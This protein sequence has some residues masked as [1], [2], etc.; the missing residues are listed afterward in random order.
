MYCANINDPSNRY[1]QTTFRG[2]TLRGPVSRRKHCN[3]CSKQSTALDRKIND[4][5][6]GRNLI[7]KSFCRPFFCRS[8]SSFSVRTCKELRNSDGGVRNCFPL[9]ACP[10]GST[11]DKLIAQVALNATRAYATI[12]LSV[13]DVAT[14]LGQCR[15][16]TGRYCRIVNPGSANRSAGA[17]SVMSRLQFTQLLKPLERERYFPQVSAL[18]TR[19]PKRRLLATHP[20]HLVRQASLAVL[21]S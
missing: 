7:R 15:D 16:R 5:K 14:S 19:Q 13:F 3:H 4:R 21:V 17:F 12:Q 8:T 18:A 11:T 9:R 1:S 20:C 2:D 6:I 10:G